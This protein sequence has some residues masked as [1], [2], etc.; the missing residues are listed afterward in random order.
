VQPLDGA[1]GWDSD[2]RNEDLGAVAD[3]HFDELVE[4]PVRVVVVGLAGGAA[5]LGQGEVNAKGAVFVVEVFFEFVD[6]LGA[7]SVSRVWW[8]AGAMPWVVAI[9]LSVWRREGV[10]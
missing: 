3:R 2:S 4:L 1:C 7:G 9:P 6:D 5:D 10:A 8:R